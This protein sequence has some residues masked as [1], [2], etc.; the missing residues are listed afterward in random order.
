MLFQHKYSRNIVYNLT[1]DSDLQNVSSDQIYDK[2][3][4]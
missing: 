4:G 2:E 1:L 3:Y